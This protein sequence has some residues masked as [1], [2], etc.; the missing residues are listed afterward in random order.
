MEG[1]DEADF[2]QMEE[3]IRESIKNLRKE[4]KFLRDELVVT[5]YY[6]KMFFGNTF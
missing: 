5:K 3:K 6:L 1:E 4:T 2:N